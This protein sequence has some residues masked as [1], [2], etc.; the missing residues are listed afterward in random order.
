MK[1]RWI[2]VLLV[3]VIFFLVFPELTEAQIKPICDVTCAPGTD[4]TISSSYRVL[5]IN[6][7]GIGGGILRRHFPPKPNKPAELV[8]GSSSYQYDVPLFFLPGRNGLNL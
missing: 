8:L 4:P 6:D 1:I 2:L 3:A 5:P 7:R